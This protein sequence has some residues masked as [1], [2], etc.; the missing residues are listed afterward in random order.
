MCS[1]SFA[2]AFDT[3]CATSVTKVYRV[4]P[5]K[6]SMY[7]WTVECGKITSPNPH[8]DSIQVAW[9]NTPGVY[10]IKVVERNSLGCWGDTVK[11][12]VVVGPK[13]HL[14]IFGPAEM[15]VGQPVWL[16]AS[17]ASTYKWSTGETSSN[18]VVHLQDT[19]NKVQVIGKNV[20]ETDTANWSIR[21][22]PRPTAA[23]TY[24]PKNAIVDESVY[25]HYTGTGASDWTWYIDNKNAVTGSVS[26][27][28]TSFGEKGRRSIKLVSQNQF[29]C[30]DTALNVIN[31]GYEYKIYVPNVFT[32]DGNTVNDSFK[33]I[34][35]N[36]KSIHM[37]I[38]NRWG[39]MIFESFG[40]NDAWDGSFKGQPVMEG[41]YIYMIDAE[42]TDGE[43]TY[44]NGNV[45]VMY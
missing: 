22:N 14:D 35:F 30:S 37:S 4:I 29:G 26:E 31:I 11:T 15:C 16:T 43:H 45:T 33:A 23:F 2:Q 21:V 20:C 7:F 13:M 32:P 40:V 42:A 41:V 38:Y 25:L 19:F 44:L 24:S 34:G 36:L 9:C 12:S 10:Q 17:G 28:I 27:Y 18:I 39:E 6:G 3:V 8:A 1:K 5:T